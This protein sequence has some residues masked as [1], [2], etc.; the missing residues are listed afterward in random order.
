MSYDHLVRGTTSRNINWIFWELYS[1]HLLQNTAYNS[2]FSFV[3]ICHLKQILELHSRV[4][5]VCL[6]KR[7]S[8]WHLCVCGG[9]ALNPLQLY[10]FQVDSKGML[11]R[12]RTVCPQWL[13]RFSLN[14]EPTA[15]RLDLELDRAS[16]SPGSLGRSEE[17]DW[18]PTQWRCSG[19]SLED[20]F[21][22]LKCN[23]PA[24]RFFS[25]QTAKI[26][27]NRS[28]NCPGA[29]AVLI[30]VVLLHFLLLLE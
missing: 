5:Q 26:F 27:S 23:K 21:T 28:P 29:N 12:K 25:N 24:G 4:V 17:E 2:C 3:F 22:L 19:C 10:C 14:G 1:A 9:T 6:E 15:A 8:V 11:H 30:R 20:S 7:S 18:R 13:Y 16:G